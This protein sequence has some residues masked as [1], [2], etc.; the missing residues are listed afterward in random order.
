MIGAL[1]LFT[2]LPHKYVA[3]NTVFPQWIKTEHFRNGDTNYVRVGLQQGYAS[4]IK[5]DTITVL[6]YSP[7]TYKIKGVIVTFDPN[8]R[9]TREV[10]ETWRY[11]WSEYEDDRRM[12]HL[13]SG[14]WEEISLSRLCTANASSIVGGEIAW[15]IA[16]KMDF[17]GNPYHID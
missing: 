14:E 10:S 15:Y 3:A 13:N 7:P 9:L 11:V 6:E 12:F 4:Y 17:Y 5:I 1:L 2:G 8:D 16:Y